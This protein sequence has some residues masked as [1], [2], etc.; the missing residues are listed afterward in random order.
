M[1]DSSK[2]IKRITEAVNV[3]LR[4]AEKRRRAVIDEIRAVDEYLNGLAEKRPE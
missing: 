4:R 2:R 3:L 1:C